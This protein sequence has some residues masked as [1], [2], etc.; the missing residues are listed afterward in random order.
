MEIFYSLPTLLPT[1]TS[2]AVG[3]FDGVHL[4]HRAVIENAVKNRRTGQKTAVFSFSTDVSAPK[5][6]SGAKMLATLPQKAERIALTGAD[7]LICPP[8]PEIME[9]SPEEFCTLLAVTL[10]AKTVCCGYDYR[11]G[12]GATADADDLKALLARFGTEVIKTDAVTV[13]GDVVSSTRIRELIECGKVREAATYLGYRFTLVSPVVGGK[14]LG[15]KIGFPTANQHI[16]PMNA[17]PRYGVYATLVTIDEKKYPAVTNVGIKPTV[18]GDEP[19]VE[20]WIPF[21]SGDIYGK[22]MRVEFCDFIREERR[23]SSLEE[24]SVQI[25]RDGDVALKMA[26]EA[27]K[28]K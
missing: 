21:F 20:S 12:K 16:S 24:L 3:F 7:M 2:I 1:D 17:V 23:F 18:G 19:G 27:V 4:G 14:K 28:E 6:K 11:F 25:K 10:R 26:A 22:V 9:M 15:R 8:F 13:L 5:G